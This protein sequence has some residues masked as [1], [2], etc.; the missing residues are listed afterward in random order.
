MNSKVV[1]GAIA[2]VGGVGVGLL[3]AKLYARYKVESGVSGFLNKIGLGGG[4][5]EAV[6]TPIF[7]GLV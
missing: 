5:V 3:A 4:T 7:G 1:I 6:V 2:F